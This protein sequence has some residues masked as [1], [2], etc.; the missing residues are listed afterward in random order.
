MTSTKLRNIQVR[1]AWSDGMLLQFL[2]NWIDNQP[3]EA[4]ARCV[5]YVESRTDE[6]D[7]EV[8]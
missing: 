2:L 7:E 5:R 1:E 6:P 4:Q 8:L 3:Q